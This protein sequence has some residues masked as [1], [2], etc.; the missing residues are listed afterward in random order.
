[1]TRFESD[2]YYRPADD[3][4]RLVAA[5]GTLAV[6]RHKRR[7]PAYFKVARK[8]LYRGADLNRWMDAR[9]VETGTQGERCD[10]D[11]KT[12]GREAGI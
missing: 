3:A 2:R 9:R 7:G 10:N 4:M 6:W 11:G 12:E 5:V 8:I 1:M